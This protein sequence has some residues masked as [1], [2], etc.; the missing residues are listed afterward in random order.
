MIA[1]LLRLAALALVLIPA[2]AAAEPVKLKLAFFGSDRSALYLAG[3]K[4]FVNAVNMAARDFV[5]IE[6]YFSSALGQVTEEPQLLKDGIADIAFMIPG[7]TPKVFYDDAVVELPG[8]FRD[9]RQA[10]LVY[11]ALVARNA[12]KSYNDFVVLGTFASEPQSIHSRKPVGSVAALKGL[13]IRANNAT[14]AAA[15]EKLGAKPV[16]LPINKTAEAISRGTLDGA[17]APPAMLFE[18]GIGRVAGNHYMLR[19]SAALMLLA[20]NRQSFDRLPAE[21]QTIIK[22]YS[23]AWAAEHY[24]DTIEAL[25]SSGLEQIN[26]DPKRTLGFPSPAD[27][28]LAQQAYDRVAEEWAGTDTVKIGQIKQLRAELANVRSKELTGANVDQ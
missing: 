15:L 2:A 18:F 26:S 8:L 19:G 10:T 14:E 28:A 12:F 6:V 21:V 25:N 1:R 20:M 23:G 24:I 22:Q 7:Y 11:T 9:A 17:M 3:I 5:R 13:N 27:R 4:P 16:L